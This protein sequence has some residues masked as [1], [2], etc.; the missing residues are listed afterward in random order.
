ME[1][2]Q[3]VIV[4]TEVAITVRVVRPDDAAAA[5]TVVE[6]LKMGAEVVAAEAVAGAAED[7]VEPLIPVLEASARTLEEM[8]EASATGQTVV[9]R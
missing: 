2:A 1:A 9:V 4:S 8:D 5:G 3:E 7:R 6:L